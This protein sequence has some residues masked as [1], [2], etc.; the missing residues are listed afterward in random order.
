MKFGAFIQL[1]TEFAPLVAFF[2]AGQ[3]VSFE[4]AVLVLLTTT[5]FSIAVGW[6]YHR[7]V[8]VMPLASGALVLVTGI[9][10]VYFNKPDAIILADTI[11]FWGLAG[12]IAFGFRQK[13]HFLERMFDKTFAITQLGWSRLS[14]RWFVVLIC[15]GLANEYVRITMSPEFWIDYRFTKIILIMLFSF[16]QFTLASKYRIEGESNAWGLRT[17]D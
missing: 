7:H 5:L 17:E 16:Y 6:S 4:Q 10:T 14:G 12:L 2:I 8:P 11:W 3:L 13:T 9:L 15:A 1:F